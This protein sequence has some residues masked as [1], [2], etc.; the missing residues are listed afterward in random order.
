MEEH[1]YVLAGHPR[2]VNMNGFWDHRARSAW[3]TDLEL[4]MAVGEAASGQ[5]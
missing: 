4:P 1:G 2:E 5:E 3:Q